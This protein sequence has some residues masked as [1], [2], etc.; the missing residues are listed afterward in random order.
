MPS[1]ETKKDGDQFVVEGVE[2]LWEDP[3]HSKAKPKR[4]TL[5]K[6]ASNEAI[7]GRKFFGSDNTV[8]G[9][10]HAILKFDGVKVYVTDTGSKNGT[11]S[12]SSGELISGKA[13]VL[14]DGSTI[15]F[16]E[17]HDKTDESPDA[18]RVRIN[19]LKS[20]PKPKLKSILKVTSTKHDDKLKVPAPPLA[21]SITP[22]TLKP[23]DDPKKHRRVVSL[24]IPSKKDKPSPVEAPRPIQK[25]V[26]STELQ[27]EV[28]IPWS[29]TFRLGFGVDALTGESMAGTAITSF[30]M[31]GSPRPKQ[32]KTYVDTLHWNGIKSLQDQYD[33]EIGGTVN[34]APA[35]IS[36]STRISSLL[37]KN[38]SA[39]T[40]LIQYR[41]IGEFE[42]EFIPSNVALQ[43]G[44]SDLS[45]DDFRDK[46]GDYY[47]AG[48]QRG[49]GCRMVIVCQVDDK[50]VT[51]K[52][53]VEAQALV[54]NFFKAGAGHSNVKSRSKSCSILHVMIETYGCSAD[55]SY[56]SNGLLSPKDALAALPKIMKDP[57]GTPRIGILYH[58]STLKHCKLPR[59]VTVH[60]DVFAKIHEMRELYFDLQ[61]YLE[62][63]A[64]QS[65][66]YTRDAERVRS[67]IRA[68][69]K[70]RKNLVRNL[71][72]DRKQKRLQDTEL[73]AQIAEAKIKA[74]ALMRRHE[75]IAGVKA[76]SRKA[77]RSSNL[78]TK[79]SLSFFW[80]C[81]KTGGRVKKKMRYYTEVTFGPGFDAYEAEW[82]SP[83][84]TPLNPFM[85]KF[86]RSEHP[87]QMNFVRIDPEEVDGKKGRLEEEGD[88]RE[89]FNFRLAGGK[90]Y[91]IGWTLSCV[92]DGKAEPGPV[93]QLDDGESNFILSDRFSVKLDTSRPG[94]WH[95]KVTFVFQSSYNF[96]DLKLEQR[97]IPEPD[98]NKDI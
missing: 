95:C 73:Y 42:P 83:L 12:S 96:P 26:A 70:K 32:V 62:H 50:S 44:L 46:Y 78:G 86:I 80:E 53:E 97:N 47:L 45:E 4:F 34:V 98:I 63:P 40:V 89:F 76:L 37:S 9:S 66:F 68:F 59:S 8:V 13:Y 23:P 85:K 24:E 36:M 10:K 87:E 39:S 61:T 49:Y 92:W 6:D 17:K 33:I 82:E 94:R 54:E 65:E 81:G 55:A 51:D 57:K 60:S 7:I 20:E 41:V 25:A 52:A 2:F 19:I 71:K 5:R 35:S 31:S 18:I 48:R 21:R 22:D 67:A 30:K 11:W 90:V 79:D 74:E 3:P 77:P 29:E 15:V 75:F 88:D 14:K 91:V 16:G 43:N 1:I 64:F 69:D 72:L 27:R 93:I 28:K 58:Y 56:L 38:A 84:V